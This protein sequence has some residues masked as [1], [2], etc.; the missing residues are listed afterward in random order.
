MISF[1][2]TKYVLYSEYKCSCYYFEQTAECCESHMIEAWRLLAAAAKLINFK[3]AGVGVP[4][5]QLL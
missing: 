5:T 1:F 2:D 3:A 4:I